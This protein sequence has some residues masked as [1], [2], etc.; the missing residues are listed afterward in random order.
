M[1]IPSTQIR[2]FSSDRISQMRPSLIALWSA[3]L[4]NG[5]CLSH[6]ADWISP[7]GKIAIPRPSPERF[8]EDLKVP[9]PGLGRWISPDGMTAIVV[10]AAPMPLD[11]PLERS[12][13]E[14]GTLNQ[15]QPG[16]LISSSQTMISGIPAYTIVANGNMSG[17]PRY[18]AQTIVSF[19]G[20]CYK[21]VVGSPTDPTLDSDIVAA[22]GSLR[23]LDPAP[24]A[25]VLPIKPSG[26]YAHE[27]SV[28]I[29]EWGLG[30][31]FAALLIYF[32]T[33]KKRPAA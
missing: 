31:L 2:V 11:S 1:M 25:P 7:D 20:Q 29:A 17:T 9:P 19:S 6:A 23:I 21:V 27:R 3:L 10:V 5:A 14:E 8:I 32:L 30:F 26:P 13:L 16:K 33:K 28:N 24:R 12:G 15:L 22:L 4:L 18:I